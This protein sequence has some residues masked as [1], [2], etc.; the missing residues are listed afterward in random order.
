MKVGKKYCNTSRSKENMKANSE[1]K[2]HDFAPIK[3]EMKNK[4]L[5]VDE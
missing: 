3:I 2:T 5:K 1:K 4:E